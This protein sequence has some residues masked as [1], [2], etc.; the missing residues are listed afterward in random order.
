MFTFVKSV[1][2]E[3]ETGDYELMRGT[4]E[5]RV[6]NAVVGVAVVVVILT[7]FFS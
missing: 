3:N 7:F 6:W 5:D 4:E 1:I 2:S